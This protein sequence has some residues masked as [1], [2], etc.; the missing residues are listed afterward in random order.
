MFAWLWVRGCVG[1]CVFVWLSLVVAG[2]HWVL[3]CMWMMRECFCYFFE[4]L[5]IGI[6][7]LFEYDF[8][9]VVGWIVGPSFKGTKFCPM[10]Q[11]SKPKNEELP[12]S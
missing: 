10:I 12:F 9:F 7:I 1:E 8:I 5:L 2:V 11:G 3:V 6:W 4:I